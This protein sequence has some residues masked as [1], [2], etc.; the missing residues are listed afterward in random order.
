MNVLC[1]AA[2]FL[3]GSVIP[4]PVYSSNITT[5]TMY[6]G[7]TVICSPPYHW[8]TYSYPKFAY[9]DLNSLYA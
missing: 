7:I 3:W 2:F 1:S 5:V 8:N 9:L 4:F 6:V